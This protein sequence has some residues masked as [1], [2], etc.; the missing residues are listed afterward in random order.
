MPQIRFIAQRNQTRRNT[1]KSKLSEKLLCERT[2][3]HERPKHSI[4]GHHGGDVAGYGNPRG[5]GADLQPAAAEELPEGQSAAEPS[6]PETHQKGQA[7]RVELR[8]P[9]PLTKHRRYL[10]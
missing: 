2:R 8:R 9:D 5:A 10:C 6:G 3:N 7:A 4:Q 1:R